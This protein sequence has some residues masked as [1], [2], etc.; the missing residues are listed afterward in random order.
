LLLGLFISD[1]AFFCA[2]FKRGVEIAWVF[3]EPGKA[4]AQAIRQVFWHTIPVKQP[5]KKWRMQ[6]IQKAFYKSVTVTIYEMCSVCFSLLLLYYK[7]L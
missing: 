7:P 1:G 4:K 5:H 2:A 6:K 3:S